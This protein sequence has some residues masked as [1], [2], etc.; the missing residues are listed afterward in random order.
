MLR[1]S[2][3]DPSLVRLFHVRQDAT[4]TRVAPFDVAGPIF[5]DSEIA[6]GLA[7]ESEDGVFEGLMMRGLIDE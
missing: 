3:Q 2:R 5:D 7:S 1:R 6:Q 4:G